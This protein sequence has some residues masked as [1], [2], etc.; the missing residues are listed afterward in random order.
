MKLNLGCGLNHKPGWHNVDR[1]AACRPDEAV[2]LELFPWPWPDNCA[3][4]VLFNHSLEHMGQ[5]SDAFIGIMRELWRVCAPAA[6][7]Q[8][9]VPD[10]RH[11]NYL[12]DPTH[13]RPV[14]PGVLSLFSQSYNRLWEKEGAANSPLG[15]IHGIDFEI[16]NHQRTYEEPWA[17]LWAQGRITEQQ[18]EEAVS[19]YNNV[20]RSHSILLVAIK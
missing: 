18:L 13:V 10:P 19:R 9:N 16:E 7:V 2:N 20:I 1:Y 5:S 8:I 11:D 4:E 12:G 3:E 15:L 14:T 17:G 6:L